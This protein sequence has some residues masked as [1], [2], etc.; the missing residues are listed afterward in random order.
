MA[1]PSRNGEAHT[2]SF[3]EGANKDRRRDDAIH[4]E[5]SFNTLLGTT[6]KQ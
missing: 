6:L 3:S 2:G 4:M 1:D 5:A